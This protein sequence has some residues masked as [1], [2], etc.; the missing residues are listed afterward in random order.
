[1][2]TLL[3]GLAGFL[4]A[5]SIG[6]QETGWTL[7]VRPLAEEWLPAEAVRIEVEGRNNSGAELGDFTVGGTLTL[8]GTP[9][10][11][12]LVSVGIGLPHLPPEIGGPAPRTGFATGDRINRT[13]LLWE[14]CMNVIEKPLRRSAGWL[15]L[16]G[17]HRVCFR[18]APEHGKGEVCAR[19]DLCPPPAG[20]DECA[21]EK[22][23]GQGF[24]TDVAGMG[25]PIAR[26]ILQECPGSRYAGW[27]LVRNFP[28]PF[29]RWPNGRQ[30]LEEVAKPVASRSLPDW[31]S[32]GYR[33]HGSV[34]LGPDSG[35][36]WMER[37]ATRVLQAHPDHPLAS[38]LHADLAY[39]HLVRN[40]W[41]AAYDHGRKSLDLGWVDWFVFFHPPGRDWGQAVLGEV[42]EELRR[43]G[44]AR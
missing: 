24:V 26:E 28:P 19:F 12:G 25:E 32:L 11:R 14:S 34:R 44:R 6:A 29:L 36:Y 1:M 18:P 38:L 5:A 42:L 10:G 16:V 30:L 20:D 22:I 23:Q 3:A 21:F 31:G 15:D 17:E 39:A 35:A 40:E 43:T 7:T 27:I 37:T 33:W 4:L 13:V 41:Q 8:D 9:C 2:R